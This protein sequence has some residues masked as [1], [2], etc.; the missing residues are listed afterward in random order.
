MGLCTS[1][2]LFQEKMSDLM[3]DLEYVRAYIDDIL[4]ITKGDWNDHLSKLEKVFL[5]LREAGLKVNAKN[6]PL[7][8]LNLNI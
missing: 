6:V 4:Y 8:D 5:R 2:D 7:A 3:L 1:V